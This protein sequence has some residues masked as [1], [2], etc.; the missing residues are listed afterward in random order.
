MFGKIRKS[1]ENFVLGIAL[2]IIYTRWK[3]CRCFE[4]DNP[5]YYESTWLD[6]DR[7]RW[8]MNL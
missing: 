2:K 4:G 6:L 5:I 3:S 8:R 7:M 1:A